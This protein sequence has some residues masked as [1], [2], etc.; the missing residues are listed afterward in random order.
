MMK[1]VCHY[2]SDR[3]GAIIIVSSFNFTETKKLSF[4]ELEVVVVGGGSEEVLNVKR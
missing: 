1:Y 3:P 2:V 4:L